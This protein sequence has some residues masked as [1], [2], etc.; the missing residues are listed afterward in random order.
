[1]LELKEER[2]KKTL[3][4]LESTRIKEN[5]KT[6]SLLEEAISSYFS[7]NY[8]AAFITGYLELILP[9][10]INA[11]RLYKKKNIRR[12]SKKDFKFQL[13][14]ATKECLFLPHDLQDELIKKYPVELIFNKKYTFNKK[15]SLSQIRNILVHP[16][17]NKHSFLINQVNFRELSLDVLSLITPVKDSYNHYLKD[18]STLPNRK[19]KEEN[20]YR[21]LTISA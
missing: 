3:K 15:L 7:K 21:E 5:H 12:Y 16:E 19:R 8:R 6:K 18:K 9:I 2:L 1:M 11:H 13:E 14:N 20:L 17:D 4:L 10:A